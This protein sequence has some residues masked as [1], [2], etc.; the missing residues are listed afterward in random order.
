MRAETHVMKHFTALLIAL[1]LIASL[2]TPQACSADSAKGALPAKMSDK[3]LARCLEGKNGTPQAQQS[4]MGMS[5]LSG[6]GLFGTMDGGFPPFFGNPQGQQPPLPPQQPQRPQSPQGPYGQQQ[7]P[8]PQGPQGPQGPYGQQQ[9]PFGQQPP[10]PPQPGM[11]GQLDGCWSATNGQNFVIMIFRQGYCGLNLN[12]TQVYGPYTVQGQHLRVQFT[13]GQTF[14]ADFAVQGSVLRFSTGLQ[15]TR[16][17]MPG[18][19]GSYDQQPPQPQ[20]GG[21]PLQG[22]WTGTLQN[23]TTLVFSFNGNQYFVTANGQQIEAGTFALNGSRLEYS[24]AFGQAAGQRGVNTWQLSGSVLVIT[25]PNGQSI[26]LT[27]QA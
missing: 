13:N 12:G 3:D 4:L 21:N 24:V 25:G 14:E 1:A 16:M 9:P 15:L 17:P 23:G 7:P 26:Q 10:L 19:P 2:F 6:P 18:Q 22:S 8:Q 11:A 5:P 20:T 27:R